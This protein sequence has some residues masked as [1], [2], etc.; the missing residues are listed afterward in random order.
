MHSALYE[1]R[2]EHA[3]FGAKQHRFRYR[4]FVFALDLAEI[5]ALAKRIPWLSRNRFNLFS[6][7]D[8]D[9][10]DVAPLVGT[11]PARTLLITNLR[12][13]GYVF[14]PVS[15]YF[16]FDEDEAPFAA[17]AEVNNTFGETKPY[18][19]PRTSFDG[20]RFESTQRKDFYI[21]P[22]IDRDV[23]L[24][25]RLAIP[26]E[27]LA[28]VVDDLRDG[29]RILHASLTG[30]RVPLTSARLLWFAFKYPLL[31]LKVIGAIHWH[32]LRLWLKG[33]PW[34]RHQEE[35]A[36][37]AASVGKASARPSVLAGAGERSDV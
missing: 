36:R 25:L 16:C 1:C 33:V 17:V 19:L 8:R 31:T 18:V 4:V 15:F 29:E 37:P 21:S 3:R 13:L 2:V 11:K 24:R 26:D 6:F 12:I 14:N 20:Q 27:K 9:H 35:R 30:K 10:V 28:L 7:F 32:A 23:D 5:D 22:F 34:F